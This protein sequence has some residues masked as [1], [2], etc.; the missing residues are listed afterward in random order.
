VA[1]A[2]GVQGVGAQDQLDTRGVTAAIGTGSRN[3][4]GGLG[5]TLDGVTNQEVTLQRSEGEVPSLDAIS[6]FKILTT[7]AP[8]EFN[9]PAQI[10]VVSAS[11]GEYAAW[12]GL[13]V[14]PLQGHGREVLLQRIVGAASLPAQRVWRKPLRPDRD[15]ASLQRA[16]QE[17][18]LR[19]V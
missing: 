3:A 6:E 10:I 1:L 4:Y 8:A 18:L 16:R 14:Q 13:R 2:P 7:G 17:L 5:T 11:G 19:G 15:S 9:Q 12:R